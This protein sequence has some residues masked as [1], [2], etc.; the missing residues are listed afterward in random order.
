[1][2]PDPLAAK[3]Y[4]P[5]LRKMAAGGTVGKASVLIEPD[6]PAQQ[7]HVETGRQNAG[8]R[9]TRRFVEE[10]PDEQQAREKTIEQTRAFL[11][12]TIG[13][14]PH[15]L[16]AARAFVADVTSEQLCEIARSPLIKAIRLNRQIAAR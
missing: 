6:I 9:S 16:R 4:S 14:P 11:E 8:G 15:W 12:S 7:V 1:M 5:E 10:S 13:E 2:L 3:L